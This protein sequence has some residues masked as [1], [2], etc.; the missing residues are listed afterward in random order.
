MS[1]SLT[2]SYFH[3]VASLIVRF[4]TAHSH[5]VCTH[6]LC[7][8]EVFT[9]RCLCLMLK[10]IRLPKLILTN[11]ETC[12]LH[13]VLTTHSS[14]RSVYAPVYQDNVQLQT[15]RPEGIVSLQNDRI[16]VNRSNTKLKRAAIKTPSQVSRIT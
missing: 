2:D 4:F 6:K 10:T 12:F 3:K 9:T 8:D 13:S 14:F 16:N 1:K 15:P 5:T 7:L 11:A